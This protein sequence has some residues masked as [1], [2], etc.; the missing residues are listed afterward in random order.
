MLRNPKITAYAKMYTRIRCERVGGAFM[1]PS[2]GFMIDAVAVAGIPAVKF[3]YLL[4]VMRFV[5]VTNFG[6]GCRRM[7]KQS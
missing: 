3:S 2:Q 6:S 4:Q 7:Q 1:P 5:L